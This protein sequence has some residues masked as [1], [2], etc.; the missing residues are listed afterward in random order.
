[1]K[2]P[3]VPK[4]KSAWYNGDLKIKIPKQLKEL[5]EKRAR[6]KAMSL[7]EYIRYLIHKD[8]EG[9]SER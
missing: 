3:V 5:S 2:N 6:E 7:S 1:M 8:I 4:T 9:A